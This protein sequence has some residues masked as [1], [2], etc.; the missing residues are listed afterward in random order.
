MNIKKTFTKIKTWFNYMFYYRPILNRMVNPRRGTPQSRAN[1]K[2]GLYKAAVL[3]NR[4]RAAEDAVKN[5]I[6]KKRRVALGEK[7]I[8]EVEIEQEKANKIIDKRKREEKKA[9]SKKKKE[10]KKL[11]SLPILD[12]D[13]KALSKF[14]RTN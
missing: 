9:S 10:T 5:D 3:N 6:I 7:L 14:F 4:M 12:N 1:I 8:K 11:Q 2:E 13:V